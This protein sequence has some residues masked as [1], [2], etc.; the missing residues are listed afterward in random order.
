LLL[1]PLHRTLQLDV[2]LVDDLVPAVLSFV[3]IA[4]DWFA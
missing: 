2:N 1:L 3:S 4:A